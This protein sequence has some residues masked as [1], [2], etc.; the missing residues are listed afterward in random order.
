MAKAKVVLRYDFSAARIAEEPHLYMEGKLDDAEM[1]NRAESYFNGRKAAG[2][3]IGQYYYNYIDIAR[4]EGLDKVT[5]YVKRTV[6]DA[7]FKA[8]PDLYDQFNKGIMDWFAAHEGAQETYKAVA[9]NRWYWYKDNKM[10]GYGHE[11]N[12]RLEG[13]ELV[14]SG[15][16]DAPRD[17][18]DV[19]NVLFT[20]DAVQHVEVNREQIFE[21]GDI[22]CL[23]KPYVGRYQYDPHYS[24]TAMARDEVR[25]GTVMAQ[26]SGDLM[27]WRGGKGSRK[28]TVMWFGKNENMD[29]PEKV[30][31]LHDRKGRITRS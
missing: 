17:F 15:V 24:N 28:I 7:A 20:R 1:C 8:S 11:Y 27:S 31:K 5:N 19:A 30:L 9:K 22:V 2:E 16:Y 4:K 14:N 23:R 25:Y 6:M 18:I 10:S 29:V 12:N 13:A 26:G 3:Y 21:E